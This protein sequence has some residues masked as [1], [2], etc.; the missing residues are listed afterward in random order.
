MPH[1]KKTLK[2]TLHNLTANYARTPPAESC[3][4]E[5]NEILPFPSDYLC[6]SLDKND[7]RKSKALP[8]KAS[9]LLLLLPPSPLLPHGPANRKLI[10][11]APARAQL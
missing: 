7:W 2:K 8:T 11:H 3:S 4:S 10:T 6:M 1:E 9:T 5:V